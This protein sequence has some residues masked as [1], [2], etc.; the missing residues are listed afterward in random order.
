VKLYELRRRQFL[1]LDIETVF[2]F[3]A[4][5]RNLNWITP[6]W[7]HFRIVGPP[8]DKLAAGSLLE[9]RLRLHGVPLRWQTRIAAWDP[10]RR[11]VDVQ[12]SGP[13]RLWEHAHSFASADGGTVVSDDVVYSVPGGSIANRL[14]VAPDLDRIFDYRRARL[15]AWA[16][17]QLNGCASG[18]G[19][20]GASGGQPH[21]VTP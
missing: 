9:Y 19:P 21:G 4:E 16:A 13:Y 20:T 8:G 17:E 18:G 2:Q 15:E 6:P 12:I 1:P 7:L 10:P 11:F 14:V 3:F 5:P